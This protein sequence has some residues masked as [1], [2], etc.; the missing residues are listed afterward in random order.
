MEVL[1]LCEDEVLM[2]FLVFVDDVNRVLAREIEVRR[3]RSR[4][5]VLVFI[6]LL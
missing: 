6:F 1:E 5:L 2:L 3:G 4:A